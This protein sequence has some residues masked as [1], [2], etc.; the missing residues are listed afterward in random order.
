MPER[1]EAIRDRFIAEGLSRAAA[2]TKAAKI[3]QGTRKAGEPELNAAV[4]K[5][6]RNA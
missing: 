4:A 2:K 5:E 3:Y 6:K 1:Y